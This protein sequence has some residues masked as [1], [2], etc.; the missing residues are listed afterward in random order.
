MEVLVP[1]SPSPSGTSTAPAASGPP[2]DPPALVLPGSPIQQVWAEAHPKPTLLSDFILGSQDGIVNVLGII[3][4]LVAAHTAAKIVLIAALAALGAESIAMAAVA[5]TSTR[6]RRRLYLG[7]VQRELQEMR[8]VPHLERKEVADV[9]QQWGY[10]GAELSD[11]LDRICRNPRA[12]LDFMM[13]FELKL[14]PVEG[15]EPRKSAYVVGASTI[16]GHLVPLT[17]FFFVGS[18]LLLGAALA[19]G[20]STVALFG[21][22]W[23][24]AKVSVGRWWQNGLQMVLIGLGGGVAG[25]AI[26]YAIQAAPWT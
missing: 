13:A 12:W 22:G 16:V 14:R 7:E 26:G 8:T 5:Y 10:E 1:P 23:Y 2:S 20:L 6:S 9:L 25:Y 18:D 15:D 3:L 21:T 4:G 17:P 19:V 24:E 11:L